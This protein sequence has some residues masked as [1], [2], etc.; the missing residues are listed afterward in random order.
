MFGARLRQEMH[1]FLSRRHEYAIRKLGFCTAILG[2]GTVSVSL[3]SA[4][5]LASPA[6]LYL[7]P[8]IAIAFDLH[9]VAEDHRVKRAGVFLRRLALQADVDERA[10]EEFVGRSVNRAAPFTFAMVTL[11]MLGLSA[12]VLWTTA[13]H[14]AV[15][16]V[17]LLVVLAVDTVLVIRV[18]GARRALLA[19]QTE[20]TIDREEART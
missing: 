17:W 12:A 1:E 8:L 7:V 6:L 19:T 14:P 9:I 13:P 3:G 18:S 5:H 15:F 2:V 4:Q 20:V 16:V 10:Y 11:I